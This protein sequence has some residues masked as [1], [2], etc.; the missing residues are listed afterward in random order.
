M[1]IVSKNKPANIQEFVFWEF[2]SVFFLKLICKGWKP[3]GNHTGLRES[4][5][6]V[7]SLGSIKGILCWLSPGCCSGALPGSPFPLGLT[8]TSDFVAK[9]GEDRIK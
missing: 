7:Q 6:S 1:A 4:R 8:A 2:V 5:V 9:P 3:I